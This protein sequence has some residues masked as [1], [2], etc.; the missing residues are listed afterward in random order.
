MLLS[1]PEGLQTLLAAKGLALLLL[2]PAWLWGELT[3]SAA[4]GSKVQAP[5]VLP[6]WDCCWGCAL[7]PWL[8]LI[9]T[10]GARAV[11]RAAAR[12]YVETCTLL[13]CEVRCTVV[14]PGVRLLGVPTSS[15]PG[16]S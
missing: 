12:P 16:M 4:G 6:L 5:G 15:A 7:P 2:Q 14:P 10:R 13:L 11:F 9:W 3:V 8:L 1:R